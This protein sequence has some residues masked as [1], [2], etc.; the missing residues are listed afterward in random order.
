M[1]QKIKQPLKLYL[2]NNAPK[3][4]ILIRKYKVA[5]KYIISG[6]M[7]ALVLFGLL[8]LFTDILGF[9]YI[10]S[11]MIAFVFSL[12]ASFTL[13]KFW[14]FRD[15]DL[16]SIKKQLIFYI[17]LGAFNYFLN[18]MLLYAVVEWLHI[19][20]MLGELIVVL[21]LAI[22]NFSINKFIIFKKIEKVI[23]KDLI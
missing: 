3:L 22:T 10:H 19:W 20:Y 1:Y 12:M 23:D 18:P 4:L 2:E 7:S 15:D 6:G 5:I 9:W 14:T 21:F 8:Y 17:I 11:I 13:Q 16:G